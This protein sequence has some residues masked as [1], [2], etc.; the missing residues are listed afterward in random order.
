MLSEPS[1][2]SD[3]PIDR[4]VRAHLAAEFRPYQR[5]LT[6]ALSIIEKGWVPEP[7]APGI[8][9][10]LNTL[11][12]YVANKGEPAADEF[13]LRY[14]L[15]APGAQRGIVPPVLVLN[16][17][18]G[19]FD[20]RRQ[21]AAHGQ[22]ERL[23]EAINLGRMLIPD[24]PA[25]T[26]QALTLLANVPLPPAPSDREWLDQFEELSDEQADQLAGR[27]IRLLGQTGTD[28]VATDIL[29]KLACCRKS[30]LPSARCL[31]LI[32]RNVFWPACIFRDSGDTVAAQI[33]ARIEASEELALNHQL[34]ALAWNRSEVAVEAFRRWAATPPSWASSLHV[35]P[36]D[37]TRE[38]GWRLD[39][40]GRPIDLYGPSCVRLLPAEA[41]TPGCI[42][43]R[44]STSDECPSCGGPLCWLFDFSTLD[45]AYFAGELADAPRRILC[46]L[47]CAC[48]EPTYAT[49]D[50]AWLAPVETCQYERSGEL[51][52]S[53]RVPESVSCP[54]FACAIVFGLDDASTLGGVPMW[55]QDAEYPRCLECSREMTFL[56]QHDNGPLGEEGIFYAFF[57]GACRVTAVHYQQT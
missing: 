35:P 51:R 24:L 16:E 37:Y 39:D 53:F 30:P 3:N 49:Y 10:H 6:H 22:V 56:A 54:P 28:S 36:E 41:S 47:H 48:F 32:E 50:G 2:N 55:V 57:C 43:C 27:A 34:L 44:V 38:A 26:Q 9:D 52:P 17:N 23:S 31:E 7:D 4:I 21:Q 8:A 12:T 29:Q 11:R 5:N 15:T 45:F 14:G 46:C 19:G 13:L 42:P 18:R 40:G 33:V 1:A 20:E 25:G